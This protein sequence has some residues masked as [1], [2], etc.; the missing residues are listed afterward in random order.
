MMGSS[1]TDALGGGIKRQ[2]GKIG[3]IHNFEEIEMLKKKLLTLL[4]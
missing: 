1:A 3:L 2:T 4:R